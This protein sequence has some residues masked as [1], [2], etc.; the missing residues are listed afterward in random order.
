PGRPLLRA[1]EHHV[2]EKMGYAVDF[3]RF[4]PGTRADPKTEGNGADMVDGFSDDAHA[5]GQS[6]PDDHRD[7]PYISQCR[8]FERKN[9]FNGSNNLTISE[10]HHRLNRLQP[11][12]GQHLADGPQPESL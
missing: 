2:F 7:P 8:K 1:L 3:I 12:R 9:H 10:G 4:V 6:V 11:L 5:V